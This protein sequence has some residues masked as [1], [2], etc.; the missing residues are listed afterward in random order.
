MKKYHVTFRG[1]TAEQ[2]NGEEARTN[3]MTDAIDFVE[4]ESEEEAI[5]LMITNIVENLEYNEDYETDYA[6]YI[7]IKDEDGEVLRA[8]DMFKAKT[9]RRGT[10]N[11]KTAVILPPFLLLI[12]RFKPVIPGIWFMFVDQPIA[13]AFNCCFKLTAL[14]LTQNDRSVA[15]MHPRIFC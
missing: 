6:T 14:R 9:N 5:D 3:I 7:V 8:A 4:A 10:V 1:Q 12:I 2:W 15:V 11:K 13:P